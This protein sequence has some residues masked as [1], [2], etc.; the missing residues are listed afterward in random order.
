[1][2]NETVIKWG[3]LIVLAFIGYLIFDVVRKLKGDAMNI[4]ERDW[5]EYLRK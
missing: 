1:M 3:V 5:L 2:E 4:S